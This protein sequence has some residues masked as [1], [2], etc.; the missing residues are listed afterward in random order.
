MPPIQDIG[1]FNAVREAG[2]AK[3]LPPVPRVAIG[4][5]TCGRGNGAEG[6]YHAFADLISRT[7]MDVHLASVGCFGACFQEPLVN[8]RLPGG[9]LLVLRRVQ[10]DDAARLLHDIST[11]NITPD[12]IY[13]K[14]EEWDHITSNIRYGH[15]Y[16]EVPLWNEVPFFK[17]PE[18]RLFCAIAD[19]SILTISRN[20]SAVG[21]YQALYSVLIDGRPELVI[22]QIKA[23][24]TSR[25]RRRRIP[26]RQQM[27]LPGQG[28]GRPEIPHLQRGRGRSRR[29]HEPQ[30]DRKRSACAARG[31]AHRRLRHGRHARASSTFAPSIRWR[32]TAC[33]GRSSRLA[34][35]VC[36]ATTF[37]AAASSST[38]KSSRAPERSSAAKRPR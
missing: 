30:R 25:P 5:G 36:S 6:V 23:S 35:T 38:S 16:P 24:K 13:C 4:M 29:V 21:G 26:H 17:G 10:V 32:S 18:E 2:L 1:A 3:L 15:G 37:S 8:V 14:L 22:E 11:G 27:G 9:P 12:L 34:N 7:G 19:S 20:T 31:H 28:K 33:T